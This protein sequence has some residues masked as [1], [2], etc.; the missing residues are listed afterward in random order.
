ME[1]V[2]TTSEYGRE[3][4]K[5]NGIILLTIKRAKEL[6]I[7]MG[8]CLQLISHEKELVI[9]RIN[10]TLNEYEKMLDLGDSVFGTL[11]TMYSKLPS[12]KSSDLLQMSKGSTTIGHIM[13]LNGL[14]YGVV[15]VLDGWFPT[16]GAKGS[17]K[18]IQEKLK[19]LTENVQALSG[20]EFPVGHHT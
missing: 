6:A 7:D 10:S 14:V 12:Q 5:I 9:E 18:H 13:R 1:E 17:E 3:L 4:I 15:S 19:R 20:R 11:A 16:F 8:N 2:Y